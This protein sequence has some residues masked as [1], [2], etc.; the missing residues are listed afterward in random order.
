MQVTHHYKDEVQRQLV[1]CARII[2]ST[3]RWLKWT[4]MCRLTVTVTYISFLYF[5]TF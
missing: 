1:E 2:S 5:V 4:T 3:C